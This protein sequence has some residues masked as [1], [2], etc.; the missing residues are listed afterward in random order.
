MGNPTIPYAL[1]GRTNQ[2]SA[3]SIDAF[4]YKLSRLLTWNTAISGAGLEAPSYAGSDQQ[5]GA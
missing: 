1:A 5:T 3:C 4:P 2:C